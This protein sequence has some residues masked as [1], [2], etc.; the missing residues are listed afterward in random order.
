[1]LRLIIQTKR[2]YIKIEKQEIRTNEEIEE[3]DINEM[4][5]T[6]DENGD[7][8]SA[9]TQNMTWTVKFHLNTLPTMR[10]IQL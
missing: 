7:G 2:K 9:T 6:E 5:S 3:I 8:Q 1:M 4:C 10:L